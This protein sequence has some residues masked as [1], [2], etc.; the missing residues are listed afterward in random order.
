MVQKA[1]AKSS[2]WEVAQQIVKTEGVRGLYQV[3]R[4]SKTID[5]CS[6]LWVD[7]FFNRV[8]G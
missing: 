7:V 5:F 1:D 3:S 8:Y 4:L 6:L 2:A